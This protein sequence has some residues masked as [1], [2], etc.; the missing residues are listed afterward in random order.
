SRRMMNIDE[1]GVIRS[2]RPA[3]ISCAS[4]FLIPSFATLGAL[5]LSISCATAGMAKANANAITIP[6]RVRLRLIEDILYLPP[7]TFRVQ[8]LEARIDNSSR[9]RQPWNGPFQKPSGKWPVLSDT[10]WRLRQTASEKC[11]ALQDCSV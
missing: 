5:F 10:S 3:P 6:K 7:N 4:V 11:P 2:P 9:I 8:V 1:S